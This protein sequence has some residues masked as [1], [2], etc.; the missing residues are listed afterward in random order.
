MRLRLAVAS[1]G[2][3]A[4]VVGAC[5]S[6][7]DTGESGELPP[8]SLGVC[9]ESRPDCEDTVVDEPL[10]E[11][12]EPD[13][14]K[15]PGEVTGGFVVDGGLTVSEALS[16][17]AEGVIAVHG[18]VVQDDSGIRL[19]ELL[20]ESFPPQ[21]GGATLD[22]SGLGGV[23]LDELQSSQGVTW[24]DHPVTLVGEI[25]DGV[26]EFTPFST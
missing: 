25:V 3:L 19:C 17:D 23:D 10:L 5:A 21:C 7:T 22:L 26:L 12:D 4:L 9:H 11:G 18:F 24:T 16:T 6:G 14:S 20:A 2:A 15:E 1:L 13:L 8:N